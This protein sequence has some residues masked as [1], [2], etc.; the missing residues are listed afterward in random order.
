MAT[1]SCNLRH[2]EKYDPRDMSED[3]PGAQIKSVETFEELL[4]QPLQQ[5]E[6]LINNS[7]T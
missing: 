5:T 6:K 3:N 2:L 7:I 1:G 4:E